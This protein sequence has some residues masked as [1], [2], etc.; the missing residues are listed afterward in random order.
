MKNR[1]RPAQRRSAAADVRRAI[2]L[3][4][5]CGA[6]RVLFTSSGAVYGPQPPDLPAIPEDFPGGPDPLAPSSAY[7]EGKRAAELLCALERRAR[8]DF[9]PVIARGFAFLGPFLPRDAHFAAGNF[10]RDALAGGP[11]RVAGDGTTVRSYLH[12]ADLA[13]GLWTMLARGAAGRAYNGG[14]DAAVTI[15]ELARAFGEAAGIPAGA[16][17]IGPGPSPFSRYVPSVERARRELGLEVWLP[18]REAIDRTLR[19]K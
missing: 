3:A 10:L 5:S 18:L 7:A 6:T 9:E 11:I 19:M 16:V 4:R 15:A 12:A 13:A 2:D 14:S 8:P 1:A 17:R